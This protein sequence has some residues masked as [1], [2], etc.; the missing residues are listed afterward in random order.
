MQYQP[1]QES[2]HFYDSEY[3]YEDPI[4]YKADS[5]AP[6]AYQPAASIYNVN[7]TRTRG[8]SYSQ[9][10]GRSPTP[11][12][13]RSSRS[14]GR[15]SFAQQDSDST[16]EFRSEPD[17]I[18]VGFAP[19]SY[20]EFDYG[21]E[22]VMPH[23]DHQDSRIYRVA[24]ANN[25]YYSNNLSDIPLIFQYLILALLL[26]WC[27]SVTDAQSSSQGHAEL[28]VPLS[29]IFRL[30]YSVI[31]FS[32]GFIAKSLLLL[33]MP[34]ELTYNT[35]AQSPCVVSGIL[36]SVCLGREV[37]IR[38]LSGVDDN[39]PGAQASG[40]G[41]TCRCSTVYYSMLSA[42]AYCQAH[43]WI[44]WLEQQANCV[45][46]SDRHLPILIP[47]NTSIPNYAYADV[48][49]NARFDIAAA[50]AML[51]ATTSSASA[52][53][54]TFSSATT[55]HSDTSSSPTPTNTPYIPDREKKETNIGAIVGG[56]IGGLLVVGIVI[57][58]IV[59]MVVRSRRKPPPHDPA[60]LSPHS[61]YPSVVPTSPAMSSL[62]HGAMPSPQL[63]GA[64]KLYNPNDPST[65]PSAGSPLPG[66]SPNSTPA[67]YPAP[68]SSISVSPP[69]M[70]T[71]PVAW[72]GGADA[73]TKSHY[74]GAA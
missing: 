36:L 4:H 38:T 57:A 27:F 63:S 1:A 43:D 26:I 62:A 6:S 55:S 44:T 68:S 21:G 40:E 42:C 17:N 64:P 39:Y 72:P 10:I 35:M 20:S 34:G 46:I 7:Q 73:R 48:I 9:S 37:T 58:V 22:G 2:H 15:V 52:S 56:V 69:M 33:G 45:D 67:V 54:T 65:F 19:A 18:Q 16:S 47:S 23:R 61:P 71:H 50:Q 25:Y 49:A 59:Y 51:S 11:H 13:R 74:D 30:V 60:L 41:S 32:V 53:G 24:R 70:P 8:R 14:P 12:P 5:L 28:G 31:R 66:S 29:D 3:N